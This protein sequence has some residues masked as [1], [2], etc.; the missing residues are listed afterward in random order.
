MPKNE[1]QESAD[2]ERSLDVSSIS[3]MSNSLK[4][5]ENDVSAI[6]AG[7]ELQVGSDRALEEDRW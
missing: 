2:H 1:R 4:S 7:P 5:A 3:G 6:I